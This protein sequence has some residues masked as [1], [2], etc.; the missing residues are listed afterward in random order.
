MRRSRLGVFAVMACACMAPVLSVAAQQAPANK[1]T[2]NQGATMARY[3]FKEVRTATEYPYALDNETRGVMKELFG[4]VYP[5]YRGE[6]PDGMVISRS[7]G[8]VTQNPKL[9]LL[10]AR[11]SDYI[12]HE[13]PWTQR[14][15]L[16][17]LA[18]Q[19][20]NAHFKCDYSFQAHIGPSLQ[21]GLGL[22]Q[23]AAIDYWR[24]SPLFSDEQRL[25]IEYTKAVVSGDVPSELVERVVAKYGEKETVEFTT[26]VAYWSFWAMILNAT[27]PEPPEAELKV[28][29]K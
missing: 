10:I 1:V 21:S 17:E 28:S 2:S 29:K 3:K 5:K 22:E 23:L 16:R 8:V 11:L 7:W 4:E 12:V 14:L 18:I 27:R 24:T 6:S 19:T 9:A 15:D 20:L 25:V 26:A 13:M